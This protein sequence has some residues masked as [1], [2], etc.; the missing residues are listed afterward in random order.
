MAEFVCPQWCDFIK[1]VVT[2]LEIQVAGKET[3][4]PT[5]ET[6]SCGLITHDAIF[7]SIKKLR[8][9]YL[10]EFA[11]EMMCGDARRTRIDFTKALDNLNSNLVFD[12]LA[13]CDLMLS[14]GSWVQFWTMVFISINL[15]MNEEELLKQIEIASASFAELQ[16]TQVTTDEAIGT[17]LH[18]E[19]EKNPEVEVVPSQPAPAETEADKDFKTIAQIRALWKPTAQDPSPS[20]IH[21]F[22]L[23]LQSWLMER[24]ALRNS[25]ADG[26]NPDMGISHVGA[27]W[28]T[29]STTSTTSSRVLQ[30][31]VL[32]P[33]GN[34]NMN[35]A[36]ATTRFPKARELAL[37]VL[38]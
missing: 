5:L 15:D 12:K 25:A 9:R 29:T 14:S 22:E 20:V 6:A 28:Q 7:T 37:L 21:N 17:K 18:V 11:K 10:Q 33:P 36:G 31:P 32:K 3:D 2:I 16:K 35:Y 23:C 19:G 4:K 13:Q 8:T 26:I 30:F 24:C 27:G 34:I 1:T 38:P